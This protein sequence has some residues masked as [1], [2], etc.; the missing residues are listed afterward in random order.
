MRNL[1]RTIA[2]GYKSVRLEKR[3]GEYTLYF[4]REPATQQA[5]SIKVLPGLLVQDPQIAAQFQRLAQTIRQLN[6]PN[7]ASIRKVGEESGMPYLITRAI[8]KSQPLVA[9][10]DQP[11][12]VDMAADVVMQAGQALEHAHNKGIVHGSLSP[13]NILIQD[14]GRVFVTD[15][16]L[17]ALKNLVGT[18]VRRASSPY[19]APERA[20]GGSADARADVYALGA[21]MYNLLTKR[22]PQMMEGEPLPP[23]RF[24]PDVPPEMD[25]VLV[26]ALATDPEGRYPNVHS[27]LAA[28]GAVTLAPMVKR[29]SAA[30]H[31]PQCGTEN[32][33]G[34][35]CRKCGTRL[36]QPAPIPTPAPPGRSVLDEPIQITKVEVGKVEMGE[37][38]QVQE[39]V[40]AQPVPV[41]TGEIS[42]Q[43]PDPLEMPKL[44]M[45]ELWPTKGDR[46]PVTMPEPPPMPVVD[47]AEVAP[48]IPQVPNSEESLSDTEAADA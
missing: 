18:Q 23:S 28:L 48:P 15:F 32:P 29:R 3:D 42:D 2:D 33:T 34:R 19:L 9:K 46:P 13:E 40:I 17:E 41:A 36:K 20:V 44:N 27:F 12:A 4:G 14:D 30:I 26:K 16:G 25:N 6:H 31:C 47:W 10:L 24:N 37:G 1:I 35:F 11:W 8:E 7:I 21:V 38:I 39:W 43:F 45:S 22:D 5:V